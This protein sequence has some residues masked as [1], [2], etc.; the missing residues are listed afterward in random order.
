[1]GR[2]LPVGGEVS[3]VNK[4]RTCSACRQL[5]LRRRELL[6][7][8]SGGPT[9]CGSSRLISFGM[10]SFGCS[11]TGSFTAGRSFGLTTAATL[12]G[13]GSGR[14]DGIGISSVT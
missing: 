5:Q 9:G 8:T 14:S 1:M 4:L 10:T 13:A 11:K 2:E 6:T 7:V 3:G 12:M